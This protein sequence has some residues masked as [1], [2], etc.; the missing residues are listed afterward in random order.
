MA[1]WLAPKKAAKYLKEQNPESMIGETTL[2]TLAKNG[3]P[4]LSIE[5]MTLINVTTFE[6]DLEEFAK[7][8]IA[9]QKKK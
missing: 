8:Q 3:F 4:C 5:S 1:I 6:M 7:D 9:K 2:R